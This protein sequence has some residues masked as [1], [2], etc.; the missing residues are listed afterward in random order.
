[1][2]W[3]TGIQN[4]LDYIEENIT[5]EI[6]YEEPGQAQLFLPIPLPAGVFHSDGLYP[7]RVHPLPPVDSGGDGAWLRGRPRSSR[8]P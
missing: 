2:D 5:E 4:A 8:R 3:I 7:G 6:D 1:M